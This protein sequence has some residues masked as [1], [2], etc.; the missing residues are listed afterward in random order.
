MRAEPTWSVVLHTS[1]QRTGLPECNLD[2]LPRHRAALD[3]LSTTS[4]CHFATALALDH[5]RCSCDE[6]RTNARARHAS[7]QQPAQWQ[8]AVQQWSLLQASY[9]G[10]CEIQCRGLSW[11]SERKLHALPALF[12]QH[13]FGVNKLFDHPP[14]LT[15]GNTGPWIQLTRTRVVCLCGRTIITTESHC[16][17]QPSFVYHRGTKMSTNAPISPFYASVSFFSPQSPQPQF[18]YGY[19]SEPMNSSRLPL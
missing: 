14:G 15:S 13:S 11:M 16:R 17:S 19:V 9:L 6:P 4:I 10:C 5:H 12:E 3:H 18:A 7:S 1:F 2:L 8:P